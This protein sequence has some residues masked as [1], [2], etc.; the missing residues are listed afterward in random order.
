MPNKLYFVPHARVRAALTSELAGSAARL[1]GRRLR[2]IPHGKALE[3]KKRAFR[4]RGG[5][6]LP[7]CWVQQAGTPRVRACFSRVC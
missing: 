1:H 2:M 7:S 4:L 5:E 3:S 6:F